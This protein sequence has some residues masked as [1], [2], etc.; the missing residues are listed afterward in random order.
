MDMEIVTAERRGWP[1]RVR[2]LLPV[3]AG[4]PGIGDPALALLADRGPDLC[5]QRNCQSEL[6][7]HES[8]AIAGLWSLRSS[9]DSRAG[10]RR[11]TTRP[12]KFG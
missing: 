3:F 2:R 9:S 6:L 12:A 11:V 7:T 10:S 5:G 4:T 1:G 8:R